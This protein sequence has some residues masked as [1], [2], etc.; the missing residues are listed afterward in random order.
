MRSPQQTL[1]ALQR[2][3]RGYRRRRERTRTKKRRTQRRP[4]PSPR[5]AS[6]GLE[7]SDLPEEEDS[8]EFSCEYVDVGG[9]SEQREESEECRATTLANPLPT[10]TA[11]LN[12]NTAAAS[13]Y[14]YW[15][16]YL[17]HQPHDSVS[18][19]R[20][21]TCTYCS[22]ISRSSSRE[23]SSSC[24][25]SCRCNRSYDCSSNDISSSNHS[26]DI[27]SVVNNTSSDHNTTRCD[28]LLAAA[29][30]V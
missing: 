1:P 30:V 20:T 4:R 2:A 13:Q 8:E 15:C 24:S 14:V 22:S 19:S 17:V 3:Q 7:G 6:T 9:K 11:E 10:H 25:S 23:S 16:E 5:A 27:S 28:I 12:T 21:N 26:S 29:A 18:S